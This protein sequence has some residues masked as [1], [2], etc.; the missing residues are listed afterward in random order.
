MANYFS[1]EK[2]SSIFGRML[3]AI[4]DIETTGSNAGG[5]CITEIGIC[6]HDGERVVGEYHSL[7]NPGVSVPYFIT[8]LTGINDSMLTD[9]PSFADIAQDIMQFMGDAVFVAHNVNFDYS[10]I[11]AEFKQLDID[12]H[13]QRLCTVRLA[14]KAMPGLRSYSLSNLCSTL[15]LVNE[16]PHR[17]LGDA[18]AT[19]LLFKECLDLVDI[20]DV[21]K[22]IAKVNGEAFLP[23][24]LDRKAYDMLPETPGVYFFKDQKGKPIYIGKAKSIKK[25]VRSHF[26]GDLESARLQSFLKEIHHIDFIE[27]GN[28]L[29]A[30]LLEDSEIRKHWPAHNNAQKSRPEKYA[31]FSYLDQRGYLR[32]VVNKTAG[33]TSPVKK[34][35]SPAEARNWLIHFGRKHELDLRLLGLD[36]LHITDVLEPREEHNAKMKSAL[37]DFQKKTATYLVTGTGRSYSETGFV[38][39]RNG[40]AHAYGFVPQE[41]TFQNESHLEPW[42]Q[43]LPQSEMNAAIA[44]SYVNNPKGMKL[45]ELGKEET[46]DLD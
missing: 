15:M 44:R 3:F 25:R 36:A 17:A 20:K 10:F 21:Q 27:T 9:A 8:Q 7:V 2:H 33:G 12:W 35:T 28:E 34:F 41:A 37:T 32:M 45:L 5:S 31:V 23:H 13:P 16:S 1:Q 30:L 4:T 26:G 38:L 40:F 42:M 18:R 24:H 14:R 22:L 11:R 39:I 19:S 6:L 29:I 43:L 46:A